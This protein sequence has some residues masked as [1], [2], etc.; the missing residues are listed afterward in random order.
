MTEIGGSWDGLDAAAFSALETDL[1]DGVHADLAD[2]PDLPDP[3]D[4]A[5]LADAVAADLGDPTDD[6]AAGASVAGHPIV[7]SDGTTYVS[8]ADFLRGTGPAHA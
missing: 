4:G 2:S 5:D 6:G 3:I 1:F 7:G 8:Y